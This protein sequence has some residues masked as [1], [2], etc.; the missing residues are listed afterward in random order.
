VL[1]RAI[2]TSAGHFGALH[3]FGVA[4]ARLDG[5]RDGTGRRE[6]QQDH[7]GL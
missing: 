5:L 2:E 1:Y 4:I 7:E 6:Q 3:R